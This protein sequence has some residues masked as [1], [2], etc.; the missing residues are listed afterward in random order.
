MY[1]YLDPTKPPSDVRLRMINIT[2]L[3]VSWR[4][5]PIDAINGILKGYLINIKSNQ[6]EERN[7]TTNERATSVTLYRLITDATYTIRISARTIVGYGPFYNC[8]P[9][10]MSTFLNFKN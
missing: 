7:I 1:I 3:R 8:D 4:P 10:I 9:V 5:P 2:S 6:S